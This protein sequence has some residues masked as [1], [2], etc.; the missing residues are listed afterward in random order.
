MY[1]QHSDDLF[2]SSLSVC[3]IQFILGIGIE[4]YGCCIIEPVTGWTRPLFGGTLVF[5]HYGVKA[6]GHVTAS[7]A[8]WGFHAPPL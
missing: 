3:T 1:V 8:Q 7:S 2:A 5:V 4:P 6:T